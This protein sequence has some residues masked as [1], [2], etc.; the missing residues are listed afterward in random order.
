MRIG[1]D[2]SSVPYGTG[3]SRYTSNLTRSLTTQF[4]QEEYVLFGSSLRL[5]KQLEKFAKSISG[6]V[7][8]SI[9]SMPPKLQSLFFNLLHL[10]IENYTGDLDIFHSW[11][12]YTP[13][14]KRAALV[15]TIHDL[16][17]IKFPKETHP[18][19]VSHHK[20]SLKWIKKE[21]SAIIAVS[22]ATKKDIV[23][24]LQ[25]DP[26]R[27]HVVYE[28][29]PLES[30]MKIKKE[31]VKKVEKKYSITKPFILAVASQEPRKNLD[32]IIQSWEEY[33]SEYQLVLV[34]KP[35]FIQIEPQ[36]ELI[37]TGF[38]EGKELATLY[39][40][41]KC[42]VYASLYEGF[43]L[44]ILEAFYHQ[45]PVVTSNI[46]SMPEIAG[47]AS[48]LVD[49]TQINSI[50]AGISKAINQSQSLIQKGKKQLEKFAW[51]KTA[52]DTHKVYQRALEIK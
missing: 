38:I 5:K 50:A 15:T 42:L 4:S 23:S 40:E 47:N 8:L 16:S 9:H 46:S 43:G 33:K 32:R 29:L 22:Q 35:G 7:T 44:P 11:D 19:I 45:T 28:A 12:W 2:I 49:P 13:A 25:I 10:P 26:K 18:E 6:N 48:V 37:I 31:D 39:S 1:I 27:V 20:Q 52:E 34:G 14:T 30:N 17:A 51:K 41:A 3:V 36:P 24:L 21:A